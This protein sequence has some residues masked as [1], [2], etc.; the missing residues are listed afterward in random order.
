VRATDI[1]KATMVRMPER[2]IRSAMIQTAKVPTNWTIT[3]VATSRILRMTKRITWLSARP[4][5]TLPT[6]T[7]RSVGTTLQAATTL[8]S[9]APTASR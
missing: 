3:A 8:P 2:W 4:R 6:V 5:S 7:S 1:A 9:A